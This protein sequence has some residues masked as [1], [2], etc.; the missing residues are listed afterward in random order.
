MR[1]QFLAAGLCVFF[2]NPVFGQDSG[3]TSQNQTVLQ[4]LKCLSGKNSQSSEPRDI[5][6]WTTGTIQG[7]DCRDAK[8]CKVDDLFQHAVRSFSLV[9][10]TVQRRVNAGSDISPIAYRT[11]VDG[12]E[13]YLAGVHEGQGRFDLS[14]VRHSPTQN[15]FGQQCE[16]RYR[17]LIVV[18]ESKQHDNIILSDLRKCAW[19]SFQ[20]ELADL[21]SSVRK[22]S[23]SAN[24]KI[25]IAYRVDKMCGGEVVDQSRR[26]SEDLR[27]DQYVRSMV[28][29][30]FPG[31]DT[32]MTMEPFRLNKR[33]EPQPARTYL[34]NSR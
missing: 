5:D 12:E 33:Q 28:T 23:A 19:K 17:L 9:P 24:R 34:R 32:F 15:R 8:S 7:L 27:T 1:M 31:L 2:F 26:I 14:L 20:T 29:S 11:I 18:T 6:L 16:M 21:S 22:N 30:S 10:G 4:P 13:I 3:T 25:L